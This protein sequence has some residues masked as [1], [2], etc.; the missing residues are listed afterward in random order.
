M[1]YSKRST[2]KKLL[3]PNAEGIKILLYSSIRNNEFALNQHV[4]CNNAYF[5]YLTLCLESA[6][7]MIKYNNMFIPFYLT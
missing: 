5:Q 2:K 3:V 4:E 7:N 1:L 6:D